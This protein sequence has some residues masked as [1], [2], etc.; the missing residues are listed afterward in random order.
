MKGF[1]TWFKGSTKLKRWIFLILVGIVLFCYGF[2]NI[3]VEDEMT[4]LEVLKVVILFV[5]GFTSVVMGIIYIQKRTLELVIEADAVK[6]EDA[7]LDMKSLIFN[8]NIYDKGP[9]VV[10]IG[11]G[12]G[13]DAVLDGMKKYTNNI[14]AIVTVSDYGRMNAGKNNELNLLPTQDINE[15]IISLSENKEIM[16]ILL[17]HKFINQK[18]DG[19]SFGEVFLTAMKEITGGLAESIEASSKILKVTGKVLPV[20]LDE[21]M[22]CAELEDGTVIEAKD[23][24]REVTAEKISPISRI[25]VAPTNSKPAPGVLEAIQE[26]D[27]VIIGPGSLYTNVLPNLLIKGV[28]KAV[29]ETKALKV[30]ITN[31]MTEPGQTDNYS[32]SDHIDAITEHVGKGLIDYCICDTGELVPEYVR[33]YNLDGADVVEQD[34]QKVSTRGIRVIRRDLSKIVDNYIRHD[35]D[36]LSATIIELI[37]TDLKFRDKHDEE[38]YILLNSKLKS[39]KQHQKNKKK[40]KKDSKR[41]QNKERKIKEKETLKRKGVKR[42]SKF[43][44]KYQERISAIQESDA[45]EKSKNDIK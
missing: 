44:A 40:V 8:K 32:I 13:L 24:I 15:S 20:T 5:V 22:I 35:S 31:I 9:N 6:P 18:L 17:E 14:T 21:M 34:I 1:L 33:R 10:V 36:I 25:Y 3:L 2:A 28:A 37:C 23:K 30:Y 38:Q 29:K 43:T 7:N 11:G 42:K 26:A 39:D 4:F 27:I 45:K 12:S 19:L 16:R 41:Q